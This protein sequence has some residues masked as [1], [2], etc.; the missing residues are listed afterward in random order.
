MCSSQ[1]DPPHGL[2]LR[3]LPHVGRSP[4]QEESVSVPQGVDVLGAPPV[5]HLVF[6]EHLGLGQPVPD[7]LEPPRA[8]GLAGDAQL[9]VPPTVLVLFA[10]HGPL[11]LKLHD[12]DPVGHQKKWRPPSPSV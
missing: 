8:R 4:R 2:W 12:V 1:P 11:V 9:G 10:L 5:H 6:V 7:M 3:A